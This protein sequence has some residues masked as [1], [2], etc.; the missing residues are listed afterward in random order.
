MASSNPSNGFVTTGYS[1]PWV[2]AYE[3]SG[4]NVTYSGGMSLGRGVSLSMEIETADDNNF[5]ADNVIAE[6]ES[7]VFTSGTATVTIDGLDNAAATLIL[8]LP[9]PEEVTVSDVSVSPVQMQ[10]YGDNMTPVYVGFGCVR[11]TMKNG[12]T[13][14]WPYILPKVK[15]AVP[16]DDMATQEE[17]IDW[18]TQ[19]L[20][21]TIFRDDTEAHN[22]KMVSAT[23][24]TTEADAAAVVQHILGGSQA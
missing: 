21:A 24:F 1:Q 18:Q 9:E 11:R 4:S 10:G 19:E 8:G 6:S 2:A 5:Y 13:N 22:W 17:S 7:G 16:G 15:F 3:A 20:T 14:Y 23:G 12:V